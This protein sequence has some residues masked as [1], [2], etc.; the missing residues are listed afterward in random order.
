MRDG[1]SAARG[2]Q[3]VVEDVLRLPMRDGNSGCSHWGDGVG[4][5]LRLPMRD[6]NSSSNTNPVLA[7]Q[8]LDYL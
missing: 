4:D 8:F 6:G 3:V 7:S 5:V 2:E 1:N